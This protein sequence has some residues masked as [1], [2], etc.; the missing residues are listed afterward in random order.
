MDL[1]WILLL[2]LLSALVG[3]FIAFKLRLPS[4]V[5]YILAGVIVGNVIPQYAAHPM[6]RTISDTGVTLLLFTLGI[7]FS[8]HRLSHIFKGIGKIA[9]FQIFGCIGIFTLLLLGFHFPIIPSLFIG[10]ALALSSTA[11]VVK[12]LSEKGELETIPGETATGW[13]VIQDLMVIP[14]LILLPAVVSVSQHPDLGFAGII[15]SI[16]FSVGK[17]GAVLLIIL[18]LGRIVIPRVLS[19]ISALGSRELFLIST[20]GIVLLASV[21][22]FVAGLSA[23]MGAFIAG[24]II[25]ETGQNHAVFSEIRPLRDLFAVVFFTTIGMM[26]PLGVVSQIWGPLLILTGIVLFVKW[27]IVYLLSRARGYHKKTAF[28]VAVFLLPMSEFGFILAAE[29]TSL[30]VL[31]QSQSVLLVALTFVTIFVSA[32][33]LSSGQRLYYRYSKSLGRKFPKLFPEIEESNE[34]GGLS[35]SNHIVICGYGRVGRYVGRALQM[36]DI[37]FV[38][39]DYD[40][41]TVSTLRAKDV[42]VVYGDP[43][44]ID[45]LDY[46]QVDLARA[47]IIAIPD[48]HTQELIIGNALTLN[49]KIKI[50]CRTHHEEDQSHLKSLGV[51][52]IVQPEFEA[53]LSIVTKLLSEQGVPPE[54]ISGKISRLKIEH[55]LG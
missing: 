40:H 27:C 44:D 39:V 1:F 24:L 31:S 42:E 33:L 52:T 48:R 32:P 51:Q 43:A 49:K 2:V 30:G 8:F 25:A 13:L 6:L 36:A 14:L 47:I 28:L 3:G 35:V 45:V 12:I 9:L 10:S 22:T 17:A 4:L 41:H 55:G 11:V 54:E 37:P 7:E 5:G 18:F 26:L 50:Y 23:P 15:G 16:L 34:A 53:S 29:G 21:G 46:A 38:V 19:S 20:I